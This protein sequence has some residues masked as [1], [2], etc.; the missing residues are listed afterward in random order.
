MDK[1]DLHALLGDLENILARRLAQK[2]RCYRPDHEIV[3]EIA[4]RTWAADQGG[5]VRNS[6]PI[7]V[8]DAIAILAEARRQCAG[9]SPTKEGDQ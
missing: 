8:T 4:G 5:L 6:I 3:A 9:E 2:R 7:C 1:Q